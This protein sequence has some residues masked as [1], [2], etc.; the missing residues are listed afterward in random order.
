ML[1][2]LWLGSLRIRDAWAEISDQKPNG[3]DGLA[4]M[5]CSSM[6]CFSEYNCACSYQLFLKKQNVSSK[7]ARSNYIK[8]KILL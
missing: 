1:S 4:F 2:G 8:L 7:T 6:H 3:L 5:G